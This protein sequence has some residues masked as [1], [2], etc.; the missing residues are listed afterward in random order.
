M[1][2]QAQTQTPLD[3]G[4]ALDSLQELAVLYKSIED[5]LTDDIITRVGATVGEGLVLLDRLT[6]NEG[7]MRLLHA[8]GRPEN[9]FLLMGLAD[10]LTET[11]RELANSEPAKGGVGGAL[12]MVRE[13]GTEE[14]LRMLAALGKNLSKN[15]REREQR[16]RSA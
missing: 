10:A 9:Q 6:R 5:V 1:N 7:L 11:S 8:L 3:A 13:P 4:T 16:R 12:R 2:D 15:V 14:G